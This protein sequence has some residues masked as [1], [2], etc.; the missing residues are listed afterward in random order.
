MLALIPKRGPENS[1]LPFEVID[2]PVAAPAPL[3]IAAPKPK[4]EV[5][6]RAVFGVSPKSLQATDDRPGIEVKAGNT[7]AKAMDNEKLN[8]DDP[9]ALPI[10]TDDYLVSSMP[11]LISDFRLPYPEEAKRKSIQ[12]SVLFD[13]LIDATG[14]VRDVKLLSGPGY[15]LN[16]AATQAVQQLKFS[17]AQAQGQAVAVRIRYAYRFVLE[18]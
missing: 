6:A 2:N 10:P 1:T 5:K 9:D 11:K 12:G 17:P 8:A 14:K 4:A 15:G 13:I 3:R 16:E 18:K 7:V